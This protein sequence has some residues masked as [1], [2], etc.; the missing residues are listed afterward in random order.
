MRF[1]NLDLYQ[2]FYKIINRREAPIKKL[3]QF[4]NSDMKKFKFT[5]KK[6]LE[7]DKD[8][9]SNINDKYIQKMKIIN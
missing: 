8:M 9:L 6:S 5:P 1:N 2:V 4:N 7:I 3:I